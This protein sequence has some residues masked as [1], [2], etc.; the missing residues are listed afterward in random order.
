L[1]KKG[2]YSVSYKKLGRRI[3]RA[4]EDA[5]LSQEQLARMLGCSQPTLSN[6]EKGKSRVYL[7][8]LQRFAE[9]LNKPASF[10]LEAM[11]PTNT[12]DEPFDE[13]EDSITSEPL[14]DSDSYIED[15]VKLLR[16]L[17]RENRRMVYEYA[18]W[19]QYKLGR[20]TIKW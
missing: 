4:R 3:Q 14:P 1:L 2:A 11:E 17:P 7:A 5:G 6:Y 18:L 10:F 20:N 16:E 13:A 15:V 12:D 19:Q 9:L 8:Q